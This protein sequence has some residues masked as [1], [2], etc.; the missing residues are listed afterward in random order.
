[1][2]M[3]GLLKTESLWDYIHVMDLAEAHIRVL[4]KRLIK[5]KLYELNENM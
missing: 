3:T 4:E 2:V 1:M 5:R